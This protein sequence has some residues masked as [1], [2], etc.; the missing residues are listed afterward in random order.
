V[1]FLIIKIRPE[2]KYPLAPDSVDWK[3][4]T[5]VSPLDLSVNKLIADV[6]EIVLKTSKYNPATGFVWVTGSIGACTVL[7][8]VFPLC[9]LPLLPLQAG[10]ARQSVSSR[11]KIQRNRRLFF[12]I[13]SSLVR[14]QHVTLAHIRGERLIK[15]NAKD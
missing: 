8:V 13:K 1:S 14:V 4:A 3:S 5:T 12:N 9:P 7:R 2:N 6:L 15:V 10:N 11:R